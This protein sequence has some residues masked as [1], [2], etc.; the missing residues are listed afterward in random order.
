MN[1][2]IQLMNLFHLAL[3]T[4]AFNRKIFTSRWIKLY[5]A[6]YWK[7]S[8]SQRRG[9]PCEGTNSVRLFTPWKTKAL[10]ESEV[11][12]WSRT[13]VTNDGWSSSLISKIWRTVMNSEHWLVQFKISII[14]TAWRQRNSKHFLIWSQNRYWTRSVTQTIFC[15]KLYECRR[16]NTPSFDAILKCA[17]TEVFHRTNIGT[18]C[19]VHSRMAS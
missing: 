19:R 14:T 12:Q 10:A 7:L 18:K 17:H 6:W 1:R 8:P 16:E 9:S 5:R 13:W 2:I 11:H 15:P 4:S 3:I